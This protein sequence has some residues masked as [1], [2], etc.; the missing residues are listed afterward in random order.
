MQKFLIGIFI[1]VCIALLW[2]FVPETIGL[3]SI[4]PN[5]AAE[6]V[7]K[8]KKPDASAQT[9][10]GLRRN[11]TYILYPN[12]LMVE[13]P[14]L[15][16]WVFF[17]VNSKVHVFDSETGYRVLTGI[18]PGSKA[19]AVWFSLETGNK[20]ERYILQAL[21]TPRE[22]EFVCQTDTIAVFCIKNKKTCLLKTKDQFF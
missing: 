15:K 9:L 12:H 14:Q 18:V 19:S 16:L 10:Y 20:E 22:S 21:Y 13:Q 7:E 6:L 2:F 11:G 8:A 3:K 1:T 4:S 5:N 17:G